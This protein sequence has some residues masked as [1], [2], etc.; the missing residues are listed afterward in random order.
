MLREPSSVERH[1]A[2]R[3]PSCGL[4]RALAGYDETL[5]AD[6][7]T[8]VHHPANALGDEP[9]PAVRHDCGDEARRM[10]RKYLGLDPRAE[11]WLLSV[12]SARRCSRDGL[13]RRKPRCKKA[14]FPCNGVGASVDGARARSGSQ[15]DGRELEPRPPREHMNHDP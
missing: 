8:V 15:A 7:I 10:A 2:E 14:E 11:D 13:V 4:W 5:V 3:D 1:L 9:P 12:L 6:S